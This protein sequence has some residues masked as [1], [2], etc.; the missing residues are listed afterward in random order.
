[1]IVAH[2]LAKK[3]NQI[4]AIREVSFSAEAGAITGLVGPNG[5]GKST[6]LRI[7]Y[8]MITPSSGFAEIAGIRVSENPVEARRKIGVLPHNAGIYPRL[9][10]RENIS[11]YGRLS[12]LSEELIAHRI[13]ELSSELAMQAII[14]RRCQG[15]SHGQKTKVALARALIHEPACLLLDEP[16]TGL[17]VMAIRSLRESLLALKERG[18]CIL[19]SSHVM[20]EVAAICDNIAIVSNGRVVAAGTPDAI[21][22]STQ[23][24]DLEQ[25]FVHAVSATLDEAD[26]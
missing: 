10:A 2:K 14:E 4:E 20:Q 17:D 1:M 16:T 23:S 5:A 15:F 25:A 24:D 12:G 8:G 7:L 22:E 19:F 9:T 6:T 21:I 3:F 26:H 11:Y 18:T 13:N